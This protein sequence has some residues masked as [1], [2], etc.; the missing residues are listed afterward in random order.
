MLSLLPTELLEQIIEATVPHSYHS[1]TY[2][3]RQDTLRSLSLVSRRF[4]AVAQPLLARVVFLQSSEQ[5]LALE[6]RA[7]ARRSRF[8]TIDKL[9]SH[10]WQPSSGP[11]GSTKEEIFEAL[12]R[13]ISI[14][15][16]L[17]VVA[18]LYMPG[19]LSYLFSASSA[20]LH[21]RDRFC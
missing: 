7:V 10:R 17:T 2:R 13:T 11:D 6:T 9:W 3:K 12:T 4:R 5:V 14:A 1:E 8:V 21:G 15:T 20:L 18:P 19:I 16:D